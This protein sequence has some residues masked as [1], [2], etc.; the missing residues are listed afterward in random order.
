MDNQIKEKRS[1]KRF[2]VTQIFMIE[3]MK[4]EQF[5]ANGLNIS[6]G[7]LLCET[8]YRIDPLSRVFMAFSLPGDEEPAIQNEGAVM[9]VEKK[10]DKYVFAVG[11]GD[12]K[13]EDK[14]RLQKYLKTEEK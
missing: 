9:R 2:T 1:F 14:K 5:A 12:M 6:Q 10:G 13:D 3:F 7:G 8:K 11:F 4:E